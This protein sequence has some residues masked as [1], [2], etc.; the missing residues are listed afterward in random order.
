MASSASL[1]VSAGCRQIFGGSA[2]GRTYRGP[3]RRNIV[4]G[5]EVAKAITRAQSNQFPIVPTYPAICCLF[6]LDGRLFG[7]SGNLSVAQALRTRRT[8]GAIC[9]SLLCNAEDEVN[10]VDTF[11][12]VMRSRSAME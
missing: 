4:F 3:M 12:M 8:S 10:I 2:G 11:F 7:S 9:P 5:R 6:F 1:C